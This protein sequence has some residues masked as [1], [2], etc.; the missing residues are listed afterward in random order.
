MPR[1]PMN[2]KQMVDFSCKCVERAAAELGRV[3]ELKRSAATMMNKY[4]SDA[5]SGNGSL[6]DYLATFAASDQGS[7]NGSLP[8]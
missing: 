8:D 6:P 2:Q 3:A 1:M 5:G 7:G 4:S